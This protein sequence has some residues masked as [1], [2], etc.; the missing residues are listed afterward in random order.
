MINE[1]ENQI[2]INDA[3]KV[4]KNKNGILNFSQPTGGKSGEF[5]FFSSCNRLIIKTLTKHELKVTKIQY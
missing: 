2:N 5:F 3:F 1:P 4:V